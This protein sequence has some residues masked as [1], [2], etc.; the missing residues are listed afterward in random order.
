MARQNPRKSPT[1]AP[2]HI[3]IISGRWRG[4]KLPV[5]D[6]EGLRPTTDRIKEMVFNW[7]QG[8]IGEARCLD[9]FAGSGGLG[10]EALSRGAAKVLCC[11][12]DS[13][14]AAQLKTNR[15]AMSVDAQTLAV[16]QQDARELLKQGCREPFDLVFIDPPFHQGLVEPCCAL[17]NQHQWLA[18][19]AMVYI[20]TEADL[21]A[22][23]GVPS[24][25][26]P[27]KQKKSGQVLS[28]LYI[29]E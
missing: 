25:W 18:K 2:G 17:L 19:Q 26:R 9:L 6:S 4:R 14:A 28:T 3:R 29:V 20:E 7:L 11:E 15:Q 24:N 10:F 16:H 27:L 13:K 5:L 23:I 1:S 12:L 22:P 21:Q 8:D